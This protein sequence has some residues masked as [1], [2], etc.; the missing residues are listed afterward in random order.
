MMMRVIYSDGK[1]DLV[2]GDLLTSL[3]ESKA[4]IKFKRL[5]GWVNV[6]SKECRNS[7]NK[8]RYGGPERRKHSVSQESLIWPVQDAL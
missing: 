5:N 6:P 8:D 3:I 7:A 1:Y 2:N 4:I